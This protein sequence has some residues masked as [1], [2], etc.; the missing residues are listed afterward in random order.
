MS[1]LGSLKDVFVERAMRVVSD[2]RLT[3][4][5][6]D[7]R[8]MNAAMKAISLGGAVK[9]EVSKAT[10]LA[11]GVFGLATEEELVALRTT[12]QSLEDTVATLEAQAA[13]AR[14]P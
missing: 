8:V 12:I 14:R 13:A 1:M 7:P 2:P 6:S 4:V 11:A 3:K 10:R 5:A 9:T